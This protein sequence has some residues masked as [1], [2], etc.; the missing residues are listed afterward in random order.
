MFSC[1]CSVDFTLWQLTRPAYQSLFGADQNPT[2]VPFRT[3][4]EA[5]DPLYGPEAEASR[6][7][8]ARALAEMEQAVPPAL[9]TPRACVP[10]D[11]YGGCGGTC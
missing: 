11:W 5:A 8:K 4:S 7:I 1:V 2:S 6:A 3:D 10:E 9:G